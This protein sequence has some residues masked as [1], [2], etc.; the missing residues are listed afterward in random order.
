[1]P[2]SSTLAVQVPGAAGAAAATDPAAQTGST[3]SSDPA[4]PPSTA[5]GEPTMAEV[6]AAL[7][8]S[9]AL[10]TQQAETIAALQAAQAKPSTAKAGEGIVFEPVTKHAARA[11]ATSE[12]R[13][14]L[15]SVVAAQLAAGEITLGGRPGVLCADGYFCDPAYR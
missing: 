3:G 15:S 4:P 7:R 11:L 10:I 12:F 2:R 9:Q 6:L 14:M 1:M 13:G 8:E 5:T